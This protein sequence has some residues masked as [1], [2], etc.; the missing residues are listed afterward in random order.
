M[1]SAAPLTAW[2]YALMLWLHPPA[3]A[4]ARTHLPAARETVAEREARYWAIA[5][6]V[7][8]VVS[9]PAERPVFAG[10]EGRARTAALLLGISYLESG[11]RRDV[12]L[13]LGPHARGGGVDACFLQIRVG[14]GRTREGWTA[15]ELVT[16]RTK[17]VRAALRLVRASYGACRGLPREHALTAFAAGRCDSERGQR[18][19]AARIAVARRLLEHAPPARVLGGLL[20]TSLH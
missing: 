8:T 9:D 7:A 5:E 1:S 14:R 2:L 6:A 16:D 10:P 17:C 3:A 13:G 4:V 15:D 11:W 12:D 19:S 18:A 20:V